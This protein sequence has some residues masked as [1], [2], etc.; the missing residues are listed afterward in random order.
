MLE[1]CHLRR[2][3]L[4]GTRDR[5]GLLALKCEAREKLVTLSACFADDRL[6]AKA[7]ALATLGAL[8]PD[9][10][11]WFIGSRMTIFREENVWDCAS[12][13]R[14]GP[15]FNFPGGHWSGF[16]RQS[17]FPARRSFP[18]SRCQPHGFGHALWPHRSCPSHYALGG[19][20]T[21]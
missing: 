9:K 3:W 13:R 7:N 8:T 20:P 2:P 17:D 4:S 11:R 10:G 6:V 18:G 1:P 14:K 16:F 19:I 21:R 15:I 5:L 12:G